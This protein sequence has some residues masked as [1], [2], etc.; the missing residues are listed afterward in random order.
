M[1]RLEASVGQDF[2]HGHE[3]MHGSL[4]AQTSA[5]EDIVRHTTALAEIAVELEGLA[6]RSTVR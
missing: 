6:G 3:T 4:T 5:L 2:L 1:V